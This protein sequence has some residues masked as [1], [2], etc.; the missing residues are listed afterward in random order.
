MLR[1]LQNVNDS[2]FKLN[3]SIFGCQNF[4]DTLHIEKFFPTLNTTLKF[5]ERRKVKK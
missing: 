1:I 3:Q 5:Y 4:S 2:F